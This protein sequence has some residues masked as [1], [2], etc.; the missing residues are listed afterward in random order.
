MRIAISGYYGFG[1][2]G[3]EAVLSATVEQLRAR[4]PGA[5]PVVLSADPRAT[6]QMHEVEAAPRWPLGPLRRTIRS[7][8]LLLSGGGSLLQNRTSS[9]SLA[10][11]LLTLDLAQRGG[12]PF[13]IHAQGLGPLDGSLGRYF[14]AR[15]LRRARALTLRDEAS[16]KLAAE[17]GVPEQFMTLTADPAFLLEP[18]ADAEVDAI[19]YEAGL[20]G[21]EQLVGLVVREWRGAL[22]ALSPLARISR[23]A[24]EEW[25]AR[26][27]IVPFQLPEDLEVSHKLAALLPDAALLERRIHPRALAG[28]I[29]RMELLVGM[30]LH[31]LILAAVQLV[32]AVGLS[33]DPKVRA[34]CE[35]VGQS[36]TPMSEPERLPDLARETWER[37]DA[38]A[39]VRLAR[40]EEL[41][42][43]AALA[44]DAIE[45]ICAGP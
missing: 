23:R 11:Y 26:T 33:Y 1:N 17:L 28:V 44:F 9:R 21:A 34:H 36:W 6:E 27:V 37:R 2:A 25:G 32:P 31:A 8:D 5:T 20:C 24:A 41:R 22:E 3:D 15:Y 12:V 10:Y 35:R 19:L 30:R 14:T 39:P 43:R 13:A 45:R 40:A 7:A 18:V 4:L 42:G 29:G 16:M 38:D